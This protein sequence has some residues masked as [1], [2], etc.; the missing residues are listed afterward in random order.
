M[1]WIFEKDMF[2][3]YGGHPMASGFIIHKDNLGKLKSSFVSPGY[4]TIKSDEKTMSLLHF[5]IL[6]IIFKYSSTV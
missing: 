2:F 1:K 4:P 5:F 3:S 6:F